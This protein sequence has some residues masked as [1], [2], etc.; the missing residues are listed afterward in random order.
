MIYY[1]GFGYLCKH[2]LL[3]LAL[4]RVVLVSSA[5]YIFNK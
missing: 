5:A 2:W 3:K 1:E 4:H